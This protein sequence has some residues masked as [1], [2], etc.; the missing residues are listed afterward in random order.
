VQYLD[1]I[2]AVSMNEV[3]LRVGSSLKYPFNEEPFLGSVKEI[4]P[5][6]VVFAWGGGEEVISTRKSQGTESGTASSTGEERSATLSDREQELLARHQDS[7]SSIRLDE[8]GPENYLVGT[9][10]RRLV[11]EEYENLHN[12]VRLGE[13]TGPKG[14]ELVIQHARPSL[15]KTYG[16]RD[17]DVLISINGVPVKSKNEAINYVRQN[18]DLPRYD[19]VLSRLGKEIQK[20]FYVP[21]DGP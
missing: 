8:L 5:D 4:R 10:D 17:G 20:T 7:E 21:D 9:A 18:P 13:Q 12:L 16:V 3:I 14:R 15:Q 6:A 19:V 11:Q 2:K 1:D